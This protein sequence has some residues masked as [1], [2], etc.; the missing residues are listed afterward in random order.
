MID[1][2]KNK[3]S[4]YLNLRLE[5]AKLDLLERIVNILSL[6]VYIILAAFFVLICFIFLGFSLSHWL[7]QVFNSMALG[8]L[9]TFFVFLLLGILIIVFSKKT[10]RLIANQLIKSY[11]RDK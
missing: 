1:N 3:I 7:G 10:L 5:G 4:N 8:Y 9:G 6:I 11:T 2:F